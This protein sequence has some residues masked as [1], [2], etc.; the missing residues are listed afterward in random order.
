MSPRKEAVGRWALALGLA[1]CPALGWQTQQHRRRHAHGGTPPPPATL[2]Q[3]HFPVTCT[4]EAQAAFDD[5][6]KLQHSFWYEA[7]AEAFRARARARPGLRHGPL[8]RGHGAAGQPL[9]RDL[10]RPTCARAGRCS[11]EARRIGAKSEREAGF[12]EALSRALRRRGPGAR[13]AP[14]WA[15]TSR[16]WSGCTRASR[17]TRRWRST[18][19]WRSPWPPRRPTRPTPSSSRPARS[20]SARPR[21]SRST[22][23][24][25]TT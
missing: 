17:T 15:A 14:A 23:A 7:A 21:A 24:S 4:P 6:M 19:P 8:G 9:H 10:R 5:A 12:I 1:L 16:R 20:W 3:V 13:T 22:R 18:T 11:A 25:R 2:G